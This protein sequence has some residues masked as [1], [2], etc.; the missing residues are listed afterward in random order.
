[1][2]TLKNK[3][4]IGSLSAGVILGG[5]GVVSASIDKEN[6]SAKDL[7]T[8]E[9][10][11]EI[12][13]KAVNGTVM[14]IELD[15]DDTQY[16]YELELETSNGE[17]EVEI[18]AATGEVI[19]TDVDSEET[20]EKMEV[21]PNDEWA[22][23]PEYNKTAEVINNQDYTVQTVTDNAGKRILLFVDNTGKEQYKS[24]FIKDTNRL[25]II[26]LNGGQIFNG[27]I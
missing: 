17:A 18:D 27:I 25:K 3:L 22:S 15:E 14:E 23:L 10:A 7:I 6:G 5:T 9:K 8:E 4:L 24:I 19:E 21:M 2:I 20:A 16:V 11:I 1:M 26:D 12:A 13:E